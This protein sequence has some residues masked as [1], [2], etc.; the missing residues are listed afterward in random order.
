MLCIFWLPKDAA[1]AF[2]ALL[3]QLEESAGQLGYGSYG[4]SETTLEEVF[5]RVSQQAVSAAAEEQQAATQH[6]PEGKAVAGGARADAEAEAGLLQGDDR[7]E[8]VVVNLPRRYYLKVRHHCR[9]Q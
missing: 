6:K 1:P 7:S 4:L 3:R 5:L 8:F 2:P 9:Q